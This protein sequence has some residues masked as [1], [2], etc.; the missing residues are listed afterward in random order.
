MRFQVLSEADVR[1]VLPIADLVEPMARALTAYSAGEV[2][3]PLRSVVRVASGPGFFGL[4]PAYVPGDGALGAKLVTVFAN[5]ASRGLRSHQ[6]TIVLFDE[7]TGEMRAVMDGR[8]ITVVRTAAASAVAARQLARPDAA[9]LAILGSGVQARSHLMAFAATRD[10]ASVCVWSP[11]A[12]HRER[13]AQDMSGAVPCPIATAVEPD[14]CVRD[15]DL[16]VV[17]TSA[18]TPVLH[19]GAVGLGTHVT[20]VGACRPDEREMDTDLLCRARLFVDSRESALSESGDVIAAADRSEGTAVPAAEIG[21]TLAGRAPGRET[22]EEVTI[23]K[24]LGLA[25]EDLAAAQLAYSRAVVRGMGR[26][27]E[28]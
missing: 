28:L 22:R 18:R 19:D 24:S 13:F 4:M 2:V 21:E 26:F 8:Y 9:R 27:V 15:A 12:D 11:T 14:A 1:S 7:E 3:Q 23:F 5:N 20:A 10:L 6:A 25:V 17:A 16:V